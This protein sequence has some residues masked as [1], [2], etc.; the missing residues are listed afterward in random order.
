MEVVLIVVALIVLFALG[1]VIA[2]LDMLTR[3]MEAASGDGVDLRRLAVG[4]V[5]LWLPFAWIV[6]F[7]RRRNAP[8]IEDD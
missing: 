5:V 8:F 1:P 6:Y 3:Q 7:A 4:M 2:M